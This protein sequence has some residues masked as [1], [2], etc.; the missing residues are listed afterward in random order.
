MP[1][2]DQLSFAEL[3]RLRDALPDPVAQRFLAPYEHRAFAREYTMQSPILGL[4]LI[5]A[6][7][8]Y[9]AAK[10]LNLMGSRTGFDPLIQM[11]QGYL[12][13]GEGLL[14]LLRR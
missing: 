7:P 1:G 2:F 12:G 8:A 6:I 10:G 4:G 9:Q 3:R 13:M 14:G 11:G 5:G